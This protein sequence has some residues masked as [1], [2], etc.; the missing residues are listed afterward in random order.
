MRNTI[1]GGLLVVTLTCFY[2]QKAG[3]S[4]ATKETK[5]PVIPV[6]VNPNDLLADA[7]QTE[8]VK[9]RAKAEQVQQEVINDLKKEI[10]QKSRPKIVTVYKTIYKKKRDTIFVRLPVDS[11]NYIKIKD[12]KKD[13][14]YLIAPRKKKGIFTLFN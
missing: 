14:V 11:N 6:V 12:C 2:P 5:F 8:I 10:S 1:L 3:K 13:T 7:I 9:K 4:Q